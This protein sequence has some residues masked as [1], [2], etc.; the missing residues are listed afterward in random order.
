ML[1]HDKGWDGET[2]EGGGGGS[3]WLLC[4]CLDADLVDQ[5]FD[6]S[7][8]LL[9]MPLL[10]SCTRRSYPRGKTLIVP[11]GEDTGDVSRLLLLRHGTTS[12][13]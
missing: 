7:T 6:L 1:D 12:R 5:L 4:Y 2:G 10:C 9:S 11:Q 3:R 8:S 13:P